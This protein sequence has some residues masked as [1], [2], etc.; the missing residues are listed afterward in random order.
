VCAS[1]AIAATIGRRG[2]ALARRQGTQSERPEGLAQRPFGALHPVP[3]RSLARTAHAYPR[4]RALGACGGRSR[5]CSSSGR[6]RRVP[7]GVPVRGPGRFQRDV[8]I[9]AVDPSSQPVPAFLPIG[10]PRSPVPA[11]DGAPLS[12]RPPRRGAV[13]VQ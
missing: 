5:D 12:L 4:A 2:E 6:R 13:R 9:P 10:R 11:P 7:P 8:S 1:R 3:L